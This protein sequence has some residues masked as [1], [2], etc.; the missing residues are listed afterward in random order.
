VPTKE[1]TEEF[2]YI[3]TWWDK[4]I[5]EVKWNMEYVARYD[6]K[7][8][9][10]QDIQDSSIDNLASEWQIWSEIDFWVSSPNDENI[11]SI[12]EGW[13][14]WSYWWG[15][16]WTGQDSSDTSEWQKDSQED[17]NSEESQWFFGW[18]WETLKSFFLDDEDGYLRGSETIDDI[19]VSVEA[20]EWTF[21]IGT[22]VIIRWVS[23]ERLESIQT[24][25]I[26]DE[27]NDVGDNAE[28]VAFD[29][30]F[31]YSW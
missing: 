21:P 20:E 12:I 27:T 18:L 22:E 2:E 26:E 5:S 14:Q 8:I 3:F 28:I 29:I 4:E 10:K 7:K 13:N 11:S 24:S 6:T 16:W 1:S 23:D 25:L 30:T 31:V 15:G 19:I 17:E 9:E